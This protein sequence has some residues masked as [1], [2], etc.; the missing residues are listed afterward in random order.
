MGQKKPRNRKRIYTA[1]LLVFVMLLSTGGFSIAAAHKRPPALVMIPASLKDAG[2]QAI[3]IQWPKSGQAALGSLQEGVLTHSSSPENVA[4]TASVAKVFTALAVLEKKPITS[5]TKGPLITLDQTDVDLYKHY[6]SIGGSNV[7]VTPGEQITET[8]A[9]E[10]MLLPSANNIADSLAIWAFGSMEAYIAYANTMVKGWGL[11]D[12]TISDASGFSA[13]TTSTP[14]N[15]I[16]AGQKLL[17][18]PV[19]SVIVAESSATIPVAGL[20]RNTNQLLGSQNVLGIKTG[21]TD[22]AGG[23]LLFAA[24]VTLDANHSTT[25][26]GAILG[27][28]DMATAFSDTARLISEGSKGFGIMTIATVDAKIGT[29]RSAWGSESSLVAQ[30]ELV[31]YGWLGTSVRPTITL[32]PMP[33]P[34]T[35]GQ[36]IGT[37][38]IEANGIKAEINV[39]AKSAIMLPTLLWRVRHFF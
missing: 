10:A 15:L 4:P 3:P 2:G 14:S 29:A 27:T 19:L 35:P 20:I 33:A 24:Q 16:V 9:L 34:L 8:Q 17:N 25:L 21:H 23:C 39:T 38:K 36:V 6:M 12:T 37:A 13:A 7:A 31:Y 30:K 5:G 28:P 11:N 26:I 1:L 32:N 18:N 22:E